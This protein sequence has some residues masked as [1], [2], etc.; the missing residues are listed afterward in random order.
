MKKHKIMYV[1]IILIV[2]S[3]FFAKQMTDSDIAT[4]YFIASMF[5]GIGGLTA[6]T[7]NAVEI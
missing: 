6:I 2:M 7:V 3:W 5:A 4:W 1:G